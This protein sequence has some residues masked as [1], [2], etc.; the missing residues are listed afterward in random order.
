M[1][2]CVRCAVPAGSF[3]VFDTTI[4]HVALPNTSTQP[5]VGTI[6][7]FHGDGAAYEVPEAHLAALERE[8]RMT[9]HRKAAFGLELTEEERY[10]RRWTGGNAN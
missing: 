4:W 5:R 1:P 10:V 3:V 6:A 8:G 9:P 7:G 2:N